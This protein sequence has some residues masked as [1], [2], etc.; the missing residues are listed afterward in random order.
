MNTGG[1]SPVSMYA[2]TYVAPHPGIELTS[3]ADN[4]T[5]HEPFINV[6]GF[7]D[8]LSSLLVN[9][10]AVTVAEDGSFNAT[11]KLTGGPNVIEIVAEDSAGRSTTLSVHVLYETPDSP[12]GR[13]ILLGIALAAGILI[14]VTIVMVVLRARRH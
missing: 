13:S 12:D 8:P 14:A 6:T 2:S 11:V 7:T 9:S 3:P 5:V 10:T 4:S 1:E